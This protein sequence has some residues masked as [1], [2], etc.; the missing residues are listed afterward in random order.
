M[1]MAQEKSIVQPAGGVGENVIGGGLQLNFC[2]LSKA[3]CS[4]AHFREGRRVSLYL[5]IPISAGV[6][7][8]GSGLLVLFPNSLPLGGVLTNVC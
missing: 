2:F 8:G 7:D 3:L 6:S 4:G 5:A 1:P